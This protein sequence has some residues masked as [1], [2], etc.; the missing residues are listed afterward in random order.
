MKATYWAVVPRDMDI[1]HVRIEKAET[2]EEAITLAVGYPPS[3]YSHWR[4]KDLGPNKSVIQSDRKRVTLLIS[5]TGW[6]DL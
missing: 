4:V 1:K 3:K 6:R 5:P 2:P